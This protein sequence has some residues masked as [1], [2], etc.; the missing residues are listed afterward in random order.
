MVSV[1]V[2]GPADAVLQGAGRVLFVEG[3]PDGLDVTVLREL[4]SPRVRVASLGPSYSVRSVAEAL[5]KEHPNYW[6][7][8]DRDEWD[9]A[10]VEKSWRSFPDPTQCNLLIWRRKELES[11]FLEPAWVVH[12]R[13]LKD[14]AT[15]E[16]ITSWL[17]AQAGKTIWLDAA[18]LVIVRARNNVK[19]ARCELLARSDVQNLDRAEVENRLL[20]AQGLAD[21]AGLS[22]T[23]ADPQRLRQ[24]YAEACTTLSGDVWPL[25]FN[26]G[27]WRDL[28]PAKAMFSSL[29]NQWFKVPDPAK[30]GRAMLTGRDAQF[31]VATDLLKNHQDS[32]PP[33]LRALKQV[34]EGVV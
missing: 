19:R 20:E 18:N 12:S 22:A 7:V 2:G 15:E 3:N 26:V 34:L 33:D 29:V 10:T 6:F 5:H 25:S 17:E 4:L 8:I 24:A 23:E 9:D 32:A 27:R 11:Y 16:R 30:G 28:I 21:L 31:V 1:K 14:G 13:Y